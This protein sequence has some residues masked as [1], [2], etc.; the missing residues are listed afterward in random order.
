MDENFQCW[1]KLPG[2]LCITA[3]SGQSEKDFSAVSCTIID[4]RSTLSPKS[5]EAMELIRWAV[6]GSLLNMDDYL[7]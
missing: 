6:F 1:L 5:V 4:A 7:I 3:S 2:I